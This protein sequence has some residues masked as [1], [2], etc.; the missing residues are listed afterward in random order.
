MVKVEE[1]CTSHITDQDNRFVIHELILAVRL[2]VISL[3]VFINFA[4]Q[5]L[6]RPRWQISGARRTIQS[7]CYS[8][9]EFQ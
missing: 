7:G 3:M 6:P 8:F 1:I 2:F 4:L 9:Q 5:N